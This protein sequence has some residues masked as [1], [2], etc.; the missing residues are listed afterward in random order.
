MIIKNIDRQTNE[1][2]RRIE[3]NL[4]E[5]RSLNSNAPDILPAPGPG[6]IYKVTSFILDFDPDGVA[7][8]GASGAIQFLYNPS[9]ASLRALTDNYI[10]NGTGRRIHDVDPIYSSGIRNHAIN[11]KVTIVCPNDYTGGGPNARLILHIHYKLLS[12]I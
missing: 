1:K 10:T 5:I 2:Y 8:V 3:L 6:K 9:G 4:N 12:I 11:E 7:F